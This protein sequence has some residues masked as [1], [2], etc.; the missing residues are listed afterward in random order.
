MS[1]ICYAGSVCGVPRFPTSAMAH[2]N[3][4]DRILTDSRIIAVVGL[5]THPE[6][7]SYKVAQYMQSHGYRIVPVNP[8]YAGQ[9]ILGQRCCASL[10]E[11]ALALSQAHIDIV[12]C[13]RKPE[14]IPAIAAQAITIGARCLWMQLDIVNDA[15]AA[16]ARAAG[17]EV[18]MDAC[19]MIEHRRLRGPRP[20]L[21]AVAGSAS[22][23]GG[24]RP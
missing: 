23:V 3:T 6:R 13:F 21:A 17:L 14:E 18:V 9:E 22:S 11:A 8:T 24:V 15:A 5:S 2:T 20:A 10:A 4:I 1:A 12:A 16:M 7:Y 19:L